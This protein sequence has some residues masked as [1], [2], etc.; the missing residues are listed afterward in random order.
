VYDNW[1]DY[2][3]GTSRSSIMDAMLNPVVTAMI[4]F[5]LHAQ[6][7]NRE[8]LQKSAKHHPSQWAP[9]SDANMQDGHE[10]YTI[11]EEHQ[12]IIDKEHKDYVTHQLSKVVKQI[13][14]KSDAAV[15]KGLDDDD[16]DNGTSNTLDMEAIDLKECPNCQTKWPKTFGICAF[17]FCRAQLPSISEVRKLDATQH[18]IFTNRIKRLRTYAPKSSVS[19]DWWTAGK[20]DQRSDIGA[21]S[22]SSSS[23]SSS[24][25]SSSSSITSPDT[26]NM[27]PESVQSTSSRRQYTRTQHTLPVIHLNPAETVNKHTIMKE[28]L[29]LAGLSSKNCRYKTAAGNRKKWV[30]FCADCGAVDYRPLDDPND[31]CSS[32]VYLIGV[33]HEHMMFGKAVMK[34]IFHFGGRKL[35][36]LHT[37]QTL[38]QQR[39]LEE[40]AD[41]HKTVDWILDCLRPGFTQHRLCSFLLSKAQDCGISLLDVISLRSIENLAN[42]FITYEAASAALNA[43]DANFTSHA[44]LMNL[45]QAYDLTYK[46]MRSGHY[47]VYDAGRRVLLPLI[48]AL[49]HSSYV[50]LIL[51]D[52]VIFDHQITKECQQERRDIFCLGTQYD[53]GQGYDFLMEEK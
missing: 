17:D 23:S 43:Q 32:L 48:C 50:P 53:N 19:V 45:L 12:S 27:V 24:S 1:G 10:Y 6:D 36:E 9:R 22:S 38:G 29:N 34:L 49:G 4:L 21:Y 14:M 3:R 46:G 11:H 28:I 39:F 52:M 2:K 33:G 26:A 20:V 13:R 47:S 41:T 40:C 18:K 16:Y 31:E 51:R 37:F 44:T 25:A 35:A 15:L 8:D 30:Y 42:E 7:V 5:T